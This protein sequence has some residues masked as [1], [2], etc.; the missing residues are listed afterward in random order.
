MNEAIIVKGRE[1]NFVSAECFVA[2]E[3]NYCL[4]STRLHGGFYR[5]KADQAKVKM[6][7][8]PTQEACEN[9]GTS[10]GEVTLVRNDVSENPELAQHVGAIFEILKAEFAT[11]LKGEVVELT[12]PEIEE[13]VAE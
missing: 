2:L 7:I 13:P 3:M 10:T 8:Y 11:E 6:A 5:G 1:E 4:D 9:A 12:F